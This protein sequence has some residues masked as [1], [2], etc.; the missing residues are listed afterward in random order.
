MLASRELA[1][2]FI[3]AEQLVPE[4]CGGMHASCSSG[5]RY[6]SARISVRGWSG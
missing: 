1:V 2:R 3:D 4:L 6:R 5:V